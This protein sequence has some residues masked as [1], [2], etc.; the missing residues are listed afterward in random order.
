M[1]AVNIPAF[2]QSSLTTITAPL[3]A[4]LA[5]RLRRTGAGNWVFA[6]FLAIVA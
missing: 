1:G 6:G 4:T 5:H 2:T 3:G